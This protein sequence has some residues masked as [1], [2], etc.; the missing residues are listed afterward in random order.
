LN[1]PINPEADKRL[2]HELSATAEELI[3]Q[4]DKV[5]RTWDSQDVVPWENAVNYNPSFEWSP[6]IYPLEQ[7]VRSALFVNELTE[8]NL[9][10]YTNTLLMHAPDNHPLVEWSRR[11]TSEEWRHSDA[12]LNWIRLTG[13]YDPHEMETGRVAQMRSGDVPQPGSTA[14]LICYTIMQELATAVAHRNTAKHLDKERG[15]RKILGIVA[16]D[17]MLHHRFYLELGKAALQIDP[18]T[19]MVA[20]KNQYL[21]FAMPG[22]SIP[23][24]AEHAQAIARADIYSEKHFHEEVVMPVIKSLGLFAIEGLSSEAAQAQER[25]MGRSSRFERRLQKMADKER[26]A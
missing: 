18:D 26:N 23:N 2:V 24:F 25:I 10:Y 11:W 14:E 19:M 3:H 8:I 15:G 6:E 20:F 1:S 17:E 16:G 21:D 7:G 13:A 4:H 5:A 9:P 12:I 22:L